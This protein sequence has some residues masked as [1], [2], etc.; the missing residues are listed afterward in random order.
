MTALFGGTSAIKYRV[1]GSGVWRALLLEEELYH[2]PEDGWG[3]R[4]YTCTRPQQNTATAAATKTSAANNNNSTAA[5]KST[6]EGVTVNGG[7][8]AA[9]VLDAAGARA[10]V[11]AAADQQ[12]RVALPGRPPAHGAHLGRTRRPQPR[13]PSM[14]SVNEIFSGINANVFSGEPRS[15]PR[16]VHLQQPRASGQQHCGGG[17]QQLQG[18]PGTFQQK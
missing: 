4:T 8:G 12:P 11:L 1:S 7:A 15:R 5:V 14:I 16:P 2:P 9:A 18:I 3:E 17:S 6:S 10:L 13:Q